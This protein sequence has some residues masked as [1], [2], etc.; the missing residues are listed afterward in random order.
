MFVLQH[1][2]TGKYVAPAGCHH[3]YTAKLEEA[4]QFPTREAAEQDRCV[5][6]ETIRPTS[7]LLQQP[8]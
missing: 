5:E 4:R 2:E 1:K 3:S 8:R 7:E 6:S